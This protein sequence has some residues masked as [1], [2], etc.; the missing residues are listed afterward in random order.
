MDKIPEALVQA[1]KQSLT[2]DGEQP[3][4]KSGKLDGLFSSRSGAN[5]EAAARAVRD[6][7]LEV[8][9]TETKG[10]TSIEWVRLT[11]RGM[12]FLHDQESPVQAL[13]DLLAVLQVNRESVPLWLT[14][15]QRE[16]QSLGQRLTDE[17]QRWT[18]RLEALS[19]QVEEALRRAD[20]AEP[21]LSDGAIA[22]APW[23][24]EAL[25]YL[26]RRRVAGA[27]DACPLPELFAALR[28][29]SPELSVTDFHDRLRRLRDRRALRLLPFTGQ[30]SDIQEPEYA[31]LDGA[32]LLYH[33]TR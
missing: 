28:E 32:T 26:D 20:V 9:R 33:V 12:D 27:K 6:G 24:A 8:I 10:K 2:E 31:L 18:H 25:A 19:Q 5:A 23:A 15:M 13:K 4:F 3:L 16:L 1:L 30:P 22:D 21:Q 7:L 14:E 29:K 11:P 17:A